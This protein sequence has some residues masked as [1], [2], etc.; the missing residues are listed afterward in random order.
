[1]KYGYMD[2]SKI[3]VSTNGINLSKH[4][5]WFFKG[6]TVKVLSKCKE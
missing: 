6:K 2:K 1:M 4:E 5:E 3:V